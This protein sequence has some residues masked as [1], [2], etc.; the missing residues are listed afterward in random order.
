MAKYSK[1]VSFKN[2]S[3]K[4]TEDRNGKQRIVICEE[5]KDDTV[6]TEFQDIL[7]K[8]AME[9]GLSMTIKVD[10]DFDN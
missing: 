7:D 3:F 6:Y 5:L 8:F 1:S 10:N 9:S 2:F 4:V